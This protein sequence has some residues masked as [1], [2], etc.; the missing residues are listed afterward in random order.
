MVDE[1]S[2]SNEESASPKPADDGKP[3]EPSQPEKRAEQ[4]RKEKKTS[5][6]DEIEPEPDLSAQDRRRQH[7]DLRR[8]RLNSYGGDAFLG[9]RNTHYHFQ[10]SGADRPWLVSHLSDDDTKV[11]RKTFAGTRSRTDLANLL[12][13]HR[14]AVLHGRHGC[15]RKT[16][17]LAALSQCMAKL[18]I[19]DGDSVPAALRAEDIKPGHGYLYDASGKTWTR[20]ISEPAILGC[21]QLLADV[22]AQLVVLLAD[23][24][25]ADAVSTCTVE[26]EPPDPYDVLSRHLRHALPDHDISVITGRITYAPRTPRDAADLAAA[27]AKGILEGRLVEEILAERPHPQ[28]I[29]ARRLLRQSADGLNGDRDLGKRAFF[30]AWAVLDG[31]PTV[32]ICRAAQRLA[33]LLY[34]TESPDTHAKLGLLPFGAILDEWLGDARDDPPDYAE[35]MDRR[36]PHRAGFA[37]AVMDVVWFDYV[38]AHEALLDWLEGLCSHTDPQVRL[39]AAQ[40]IG[41]LA[42]YDFDFIEQRYFIRWSGGAKRVLHETTAYALEAAVAYDGRRFER[43]FERAEQWAKGTLAQ[44][45]TAT[46]LLGT[47]LGVRDPARAMRILRQIAVSQ[48]KALRSPLIWSIVEMFAGGSGLAVLDALRSWARSPHPAVRRLT[49]LSLAELARIGR[50]Y[51]LPDDRKGSAREQNV[52]PLM[53]FY[54]RSSVRVI[55]LWLQVLTSRTCGPEPW[56]ALRAWQKAGVDFTALRKALER[57][58]RLRAPLKFYLGPSQPLRDRIQHTEESTA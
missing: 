41:R 36:L 31:L 56:N 30:I 4:N 10:A 11:L 53:A 24:V 57:E 33:E 9:D 15:G 43:V 45:S 16:A 35:T 21:R 58:P 25:S 23:D 47:V 48:P 8:I 39:K 42:S 50:G 2:G 37:R 13:K 14:I 12:A 40:A 44:Q 18:A 32:Q 34:D 55:D 17:A 29:E 1:T 20:N 22:D 3:E 26:H 52:P 49:A 19:I 51:L 27:L 54:D 38:I 6:P 46:Q 5:N 28:H 7:E